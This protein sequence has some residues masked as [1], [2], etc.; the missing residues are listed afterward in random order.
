[1]MIS[2][3][4]HKH[5]CTAAYAVA[6]EPRGDENALPRRDRYAAAAPLKLPGSVKAK[7]GVEGC[8]VGVKAIAV[9]AEANGKIPAGGK[10][11]FSVARK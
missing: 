11:V 1:M 6:A 4:A 8:T 10:H 3:S 7:Y 2:R 9:R 5:T